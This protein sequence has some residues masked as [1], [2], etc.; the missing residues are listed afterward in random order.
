MVWTFGKIP[1]KSTSYQVMIYD[2]GSYK[3]VKEYL[4][5]FQTTHLFISFKEIDPESQREY[6]RSYVEYTGPI[7]LRV[8]NMLPGT[9]IYCSRKVLKK[10]IGCLLKY[11][12]LLD[13]IGLNPTECNES[14]DVVSLDY[15]LRPET[16]IEVPK[17]LEPKS[18]VNPKPL[19]KLSKPFV[20][21]D[22]EA[23]EY[24][25]IRLDNLDAKLNM[26]LGMLE[27]ILENKVNK[28]GI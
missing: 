25:D 16:C 2:I 20:I 19:L 1:N 4:T 3:N 28:F 15:F 13:V 5:H 11:E 27:C 26:V 17:H 12:N 9:I 24:S 8:H 7:K 10:D 21:V 18:K 23:S 14:F 6:V 22:K